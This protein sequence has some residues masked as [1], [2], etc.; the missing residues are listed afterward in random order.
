MK[1][2]GGEGPSDFGAGSITVTIGDYEI[3]VNLSEMTDAGI[4]FSF[5]NGEL[6]GAGT[7]T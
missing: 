5:E 3:T 7:I 1:T 4:S 6:T 2:R